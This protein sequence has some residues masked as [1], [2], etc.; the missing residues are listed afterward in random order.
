M[1]VAGIGWCKSKTKLIDFVCKKD[2]NESGRD[3]E[4]DEEGRECPAVR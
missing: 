2:A 1:W 4:G 3:L